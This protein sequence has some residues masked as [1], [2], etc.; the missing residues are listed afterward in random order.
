PFGS[1][2]SALQVEA[3][4]KLTFGLIDTEYGPDEVTDLGL[5]KNGWAAVSELSG[6]AAKAPAGSAYGDA[7]TV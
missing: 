4:G 7:L 2:R 6:I 5:I 3:D 1:K